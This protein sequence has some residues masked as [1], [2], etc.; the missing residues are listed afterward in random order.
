M[1]KLFVFILLFTSIFS[2]SQDKEKRIDRVKALRVAFI[3]D[4]LDLT[5]DEAQKFWP[6]FNQYDERQHELRKQKRH[7]MHQLRPENTMGL[8]EKETAA[9]MTQDDK[10]EDDMQENKRKLVKDLQG[11]IPTQKILLLKQLEIEFKEKLLE[12]MRNRKSRKP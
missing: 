10:L 2:F 5:T 11:V 6:V 3:S 9:L 12:Q 7:L 1:K 8:S 4:R